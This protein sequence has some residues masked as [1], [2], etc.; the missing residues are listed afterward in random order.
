MKLQEILD[1]YFTDGKSLYFRSSDSLSNIEG[2]TYLRYRKNG[3]I[4]IWFGGNNGE[5]CIYC[6]TDPIKL[7]AL[8]KSIIF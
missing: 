6:T 3:T 8:T 7:E 1:K 5:V 4:E 2:D